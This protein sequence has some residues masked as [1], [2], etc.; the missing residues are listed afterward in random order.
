[1]LPSVVCQ[2]LKTENTDLQQLL[3]GECH[4]HIKDS[5]RGQAAVTPEEDKAIGLLAFRTVRDNPMQ[6]LQEL[7][8]EEGI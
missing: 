7:S 8:G 6:G 5:V 4:E 1:M 2:L 3:P